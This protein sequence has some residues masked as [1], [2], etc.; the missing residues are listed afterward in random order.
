MAIDLG[1]HRV[2]VRGKEVSLSPT[3]FKL[4]CEL[5]THAGRVLLHEDLL[6]VLGT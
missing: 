6:R 5:A 2:T 4:L 3:E 1:R